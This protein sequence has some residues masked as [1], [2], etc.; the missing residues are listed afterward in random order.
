MAVLGRLLLGA[1]GKAWAIVGPLF[2][3]FAWKKIQGWIAAWKAKREIKAA[4]RA[5]REATE[6]AQTAKEREDA[7]DQNRRL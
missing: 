2:L 6:A 4:A 5:E 7:A 3:D 1:L